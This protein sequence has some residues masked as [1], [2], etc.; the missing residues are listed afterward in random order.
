MSIN[1]IFEIAILGDSLCLAHRPLCLA[2]LP[3]LAR[4]ATA[5]SLSLPEFAACMQRMFDK[6]PTLRGIPRITLLETLFI[7]GPIP[8]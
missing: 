2:M 6:A 3:M 1:C 4:S 5:K 8:S 7:A